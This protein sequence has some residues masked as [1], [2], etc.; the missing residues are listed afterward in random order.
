MARAAVAALIAV[1]L[2]PA[3][4]AAKLPRD[5]FGVMA[6]GPLDAPSFPLDAESAAM[7]S[8]GIGSERMEFAWDVIE[9]QPGVYDFALTDR[10]VL[11][12]AR[13]GIHV[14]GFV[15]RSPAWAAREPGKVFSPPRNPANFAD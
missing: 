6:N 2:L 10:K 5:F 7:R 12:A 8:A 1:L 9:P 11:A 15:L 13:A 3:T 4:A 14:L